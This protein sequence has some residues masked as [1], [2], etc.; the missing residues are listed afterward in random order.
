MGGWAA[1]PGPASNG[2]N[3]AGE[4]I[5]RLVKYIINPAILLIFTAGFLLFLWGLVV[6]IFKLEEGGDH[7]EGKNHMLYGLIGMLVMV[8]VGGIIAILSNTFDLRVDPKSGTYNPDLSR[9]DNVLP[10]AN[11]FGSVR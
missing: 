4:L 8:S 5:G 2:M 3:V 7:K 11:F 1:G 9:M 10:A 6:F